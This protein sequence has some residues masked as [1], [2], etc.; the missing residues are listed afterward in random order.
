MGMKFFNKNKPN[1]F[2]QIGAMKSKYPQFKAK[3]LSNDTVTFIGDLLIKPELP[4]YTVSVEYRG[5]LSPRVRVIEPK[6]VENRP[7][8]YK[9]T[10]CLC[11]YHPDDFKWD[12][13]KLVAKEIMSWTIAWL[14]FYEAW[15]QTGKFLGPESHHTPNTIKEDKDE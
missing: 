15:L 5:T 13:R 2:A 4:I 6:L 8:F 3:H 1:V 14:Y 12:C 11:L 10:E 9:N 7:H